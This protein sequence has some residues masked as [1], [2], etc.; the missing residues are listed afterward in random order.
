MKNNIFNIFG[1]IPGA[2]SIWKNEHP[3]FLFSLCRDHP[4]EVSMLRN[5]HFKLTQF[6]ATALGTV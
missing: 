3:N 5:F 6:F 1:E 2:F 4:V